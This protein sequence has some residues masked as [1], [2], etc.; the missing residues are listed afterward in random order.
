[1][2]IPSDRPAMRGEGRW[3]AAG[4]ARKNQTRPE[5]VQPNNA[6]DSRVKEQAGL[7][8]W[9]LDYGAW[10]SALRVLRLLLEK[11]VVLGSPG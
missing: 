6:H 10:H 9:G 4:M 7:P 5:G 11:D 3:S 8:S 1:M 2:G